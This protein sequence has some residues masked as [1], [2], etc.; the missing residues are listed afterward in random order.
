[1]QQQRSTLWA[2]EEGSQLFEYIAVLPFLMAIILIGWQF[3]LVGH[4]FIV[5]ANA[6]RE[7]ARALA[8]CN[9]SAGAAR[10]AAMRSLP[11]GYQAGA[12]VEPQN[13]QSVTV[14]VKTDIPVIDIFKDYDE[15]LPSVRFKAVMRKE[16]CP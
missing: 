12:S 1:M 6:A 5:T 11:Q 2:E 15:W 13:G 4:T 7:G 9:S 14:W 8:V 16:R 3:F 10:E